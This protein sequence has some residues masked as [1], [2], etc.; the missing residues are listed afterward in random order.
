MTA[1]KSDPAG[2][3]LFLPFPGGVSRDAVHDATHFRTTWLSFSLRTLTRHGLAERYFASLAPAFH[4]D[5]R[6]L[7]AGQWQPMRLALAHY[8]ACDR[9]ELPE[10]EIFAIGKESGAGVHGAIYKAMLR[11]A[12]EAGAT[13]WSALTGAHAEW[14]RS[15]RGAGMAVYRLGPKEARMEYAG[16]P[17]A[18]LRYVRL[19]VRGV[20]AGVFEL[21]GAKAY[22]HEVAELCGA[23]T[24]AY[25]VA[26]V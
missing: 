9:L 20:I 26:W 25:R 6:S 4:G 19:A 7:V 24:L 8:E 16:Y 17:F 18:H 14:H 2:G 5:M 3:A 11:V 13:P 10:S 22:V 1:A 23:K 15:W 21:V 12:K